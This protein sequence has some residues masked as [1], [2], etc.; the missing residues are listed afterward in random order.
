MTVLLD[1]DYMEI[2][3]HGNEIDPVAWLKDIKVMMWQ[4]PFV[5]LVGD[6]FV[7]GKDLAISDYLAIDYLPM[8]DLWDH[9]FV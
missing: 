1:Q 2:L 6:I 7:D 3:C 4:M 9:V 8:S 5:M